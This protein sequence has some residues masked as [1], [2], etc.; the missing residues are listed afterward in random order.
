MN[1]ELGKKGERHEHGTEARSAP[2]N[3]H[4]GLPPGPR[5]PATMQAFGWSLRPLPFME[6]CRRAVR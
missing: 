4:N 1:N 3:G 5:M 2:S 6:R